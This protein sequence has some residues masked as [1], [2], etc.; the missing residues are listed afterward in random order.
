MA[1]ISSGVALENSF[2]S[3]LWSGASPT[4]C[5]KMRLISKDNR[6]QSDSSLNPEKKEE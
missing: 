3:V 2:R 1:S 6:A 5:A 4:L